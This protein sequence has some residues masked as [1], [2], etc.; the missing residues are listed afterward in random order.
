[1]FTKHY[2]LCAV[3]L[4]LH[5]IHQSQ[6]LFSALFNHTSSDQD[7][8]PKSKHFVYDAAFKLK[9]NELA[10]NRGSGATAQELGINRFIGREWRKQGG[11]Q[12]WC[13]KTTIA[14]LGT[15]FR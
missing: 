3:G 8:M 2:T 14:F 1:M 13:Q 11:E 5:T 9:A 12:T 4:D 15:V 6:I 10:I 7:I